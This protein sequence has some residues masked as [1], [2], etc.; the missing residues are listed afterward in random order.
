MNKAKKILGLF[1]E[2]YGSRFSNPE[3]KKLSAE[4][5]TLSSGTI[6]SL[7]GFKDYKE[8]QKFQDSFANWVSDRPENFQTWQNAYHAFMKHNNITVDSKGKADPEEIRN[9][10]W[11]K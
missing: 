8:V 1:K 9:K 11:F 4:I 7:T 2:Q 3:N 10:L 5:D 6:G